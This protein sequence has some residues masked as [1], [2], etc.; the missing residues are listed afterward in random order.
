MRNSRPSLDIIEIDNM[1][2]NQNIEELSLQEL[3]SKAAGELDDA[4]WNGFRKKAYEYYE[5]FMSSLY[6]YA[7][8]TRAADKADYFEGTSRSLKRMYELGIKMEDFYKNLSLCS[9]GSQLFDEGYWL[10]RRGKNPGEQIKICQEWLDK[11]YVKY[12]SWEQFLNGE[13]RNNVSKWRGQFDK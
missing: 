13:W 9:D 3:I 6:G 5:G 4:T 11:M 8:A 2:E 10:L 1:E 12:P 7:T